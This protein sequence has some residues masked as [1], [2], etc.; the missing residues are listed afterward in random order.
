MTVALYCADPDGNQME[1]QVDCLGSPEEAREFMSTM[2]SQN[3]IGLEFD[4]EACLA[5]QQSGTPEAELLERKTH[6]PVS[7]VRGA[8]SRYVQGS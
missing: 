7:P 2:F 6:E 1:F 5:Q 3:S 8:F 4:P